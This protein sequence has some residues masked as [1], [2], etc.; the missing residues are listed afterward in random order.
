VVAGDAAQTKEWIQINTGAIKRNCYWKENFLEEPI[1][2][3]IKAKFEDPNIQI[4]M[5]VAATELHPWKHVM[6]DGFY[7]NNFKWR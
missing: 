6:P 4:P 5:V 3:T 2:K 7:L 1:T